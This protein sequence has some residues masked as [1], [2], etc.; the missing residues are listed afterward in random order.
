MRRH[1]AIVLTVVVAVAVL[2]AVWWG[3]NAVLRVTTLD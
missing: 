1:H 2:I 3:F